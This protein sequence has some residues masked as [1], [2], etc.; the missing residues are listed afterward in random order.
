MLA[1]AVM[2]RPQLLNAV[3]PD[4]L[5][6]SLIKSVASGKPSGPS[7]SSSLPSEDQ[8]KAVADKRGRYATVLVACASFGDQGGLNKMEREVLVVDWVVLAHY[9]AIC[10]SLVSCRW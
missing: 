3:L 7:V 9:P 4:A 2:K 6:T 1:E 10:T 5:T 8:E